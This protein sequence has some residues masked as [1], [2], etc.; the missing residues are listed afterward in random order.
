MVGKT[1]EGF[2]LLGNFGF[3]KSER[4]EVDF[5]M[6][7]GFLGSD[8]KAFT[9]LAVGWGSIHSVLVALAFL[10]R[11]IFSSSVSSLFF[12]F[13]S[14]SMLVALSADFSSMR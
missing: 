9:G 8:E 1:V 11:N 5:L 14:G 3:C 13:T 10:I 2:G 4:K 12:S 7:L 6:S